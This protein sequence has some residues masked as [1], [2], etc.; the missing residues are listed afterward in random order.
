VRGASSTAALA[1][2]DPLIAAVPALAG[3]AAGLL[4]VRL[5][6]VPMRLLA[7]LASSRR[8]LV[9]VLALRRATGGAGAAPVLIVL[10]ATATIGA[11]S[12]AALVHLERAAETVAWQEVGGAY[13]IASPAGALPGTLR[14]GEL[15]GAEAATTV[16]RQTVPVGTTGPRLELVVLDVPTY[17]DVV[18]GTPADPGL[19]A[20]LLG[21][22]ASPIP[23]LVS[24]SLGAR[25]DGVAAGETFQL[26]VEG[27]TL[28]YRAAVVR[29]TFPGVAPNT[30]F[31]VVSRAHFLA[32]APPAR[33]APGAALVRA[34]AEAADAI[35][36]TAL[37]VVAGGRVESRAE[38]TSALRE[39]P[40]ADAVRGGIIAA[41]VIAGVYAALAVAAALALAGLSRAV[42]V[43]HLRT[44]G[45]TR[46]EAF[47]LVAVE[48]APTIVTALVLGI[49]LGLGLFLLLRPGLGLSALVGSAIDVPLTVDPGQL[50]LVLAAGVAVVGLGLL[51]GAVLQ[52]AAVPA[53]AIRR[54]FE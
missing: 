5:L 15:P 42:E 11:F 26:S 21:P 19:P 41:V 29:D 18:R 24:S 33:I 39:S 35:R 34:P 23:A 10:L 12:S 2:A 8:G 16:F 20:E 31:A 1:A 37:E 30:H 48:H 53:A 36:S 45:L 49:A 50:A 38:R 28:T 7:W 54:G 32:A 43:A 17:R 3:I 14:A 4:A 46:R 51:V 47:G 13:R 27:F 6:P 22:A 52:R 25:P 9:P 40:V 44:L